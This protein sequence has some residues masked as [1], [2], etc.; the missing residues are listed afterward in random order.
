MNKKPLKYSEKHAK[1]YGV[2][3]T[4]NEGTINGEETERQLLGKSD[5]MFQMLSETNSYGG[6][7]VAGNLGAKDGRSQSPSRT[8]NSSQTNPDINNTIDVN[9]PYAT[10]NVSGV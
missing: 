1:V 9:D 8:M 5:V 2:V 6:F 4:P 7:P 3:E 10:K